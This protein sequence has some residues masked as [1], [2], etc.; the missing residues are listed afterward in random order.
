MNDRDARDRGVLTLLVQLFGREVLDR[1]A[2]AGFEDEASISLAGAD[3]LAAE[4]GISPSVAQ[5]IAAVVDEIRRPSRRPAQATDEPA[6]GPPRE[7]RHRKAPARHAASKTEIKRAESAARPAGKD[8]D[9]PFVDDVALVAWMGFSSKNP[10]GRLSFSVA[11]EILGPVWRE[12]RA[13]EGTR[14]NAAEEAPVASST[15]PQVGTAPRAEGEETPG[16]QNPSAAAPARTLPGSFWS[17]GRAAEP[18]GANDDAVARPSGRT[19]E[20]EVPADPL[21]RRNRHDH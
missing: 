20:P 19:A 7:P 5:R 15:A 21:P 10:S 17:F 4:S 13:F 11:D 8:R 14:L 12:P 1:L 2:R 18:P 3:R 6:G 16:G 9:D